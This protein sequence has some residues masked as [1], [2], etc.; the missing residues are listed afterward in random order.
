MLPGS[1]GSADSKT[2]SQREVWAVLSFPPF[3]LRPCSHSLEPGRSGMELGLFFC[4]WLVQLAHIRL[5]SS[6]RPSSIRLCH[7]L[8]AHSA[9]RVASTLWPLCLLQLFRSYF[10]FFGVWT[11]T[12]NCWIIMDKGS[13]ALFSESSHGSESGV[14]CRV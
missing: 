13:H 14:V 9:A 12:Q 7:V 1:R 3:T 10:Q 5:Y 11:Q 6:K 4:S 8:K 2:N